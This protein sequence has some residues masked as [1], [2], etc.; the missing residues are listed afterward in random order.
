M[1][2][3]SSCCLVSVFSS[4][5]AAIPGSD[6]LHGDRRAEVKAP[7]PHEWRCPCSFWGPASAGETRGNPAASPP[8]QEEQEQPGEMELRWD[9]AGLGLEMGLEMC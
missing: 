9:G 8:A 2:Q 5:M 1:L 3:G 6:S 4:G 7:V